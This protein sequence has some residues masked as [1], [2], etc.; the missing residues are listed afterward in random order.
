M[1][2]LHES[3]A[4]LARGLEGVKALLVIEGSGI[5]VAT[6][7]DG[8]FEAAAAEFA[9]LWR[10]LGVAEALHR[11]GAT[12]ALT[13]HGAQGAWVAVPLGEDY[14]LA[15]LA[16]AKMPAGKAQFYATE[17]AHRHREEFA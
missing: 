8:D 17:W 10:Q 3:L 6:W 15:V 13:F 7:G 14:V 1:T 2:D 12:K 5:E 4:E 16:G 11:A 9:E